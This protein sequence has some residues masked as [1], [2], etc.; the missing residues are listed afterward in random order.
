M[1]DKIKF[2]KQSSGSNNGMG[3]SLS[4]NALSKALT[5]VDSGIFKMSQNTSDKSGVSSRGDS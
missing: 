2:K 5:N 1:T 4:T 3:T